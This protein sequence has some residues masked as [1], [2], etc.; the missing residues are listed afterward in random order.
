MA[1]SWCRF[2][3]GRDVLERFAG[4]LDIYSKTQRST[5]NEMTDTAEK[6]PVCMDAEFAAGA[7]AALRTIIQLDGEVEP[8]AFVSMVMSRSGA[9]SDGR[10]ER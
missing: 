8:D 1:Y 10:E 2:T 9:V 7:S 5:L 4:A 6:L 3:I